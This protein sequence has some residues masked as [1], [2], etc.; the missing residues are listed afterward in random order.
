MVAN[1][2]LTP[3]RLLEEVRI[4]IPRLKQMRAA[5]RNL[6]PADAAEKLAREIL[7]LA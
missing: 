4:V 2:Q 5:A 1:N 7:E 3:A 6:M